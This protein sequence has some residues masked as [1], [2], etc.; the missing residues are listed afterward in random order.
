MKIVEV[1]PIVV[2]VPLREPVKDVHGV[3][4]VQRSVLVRVRTDVG[5]EGWGNVDPHAGLLAGLGA[6]HPR[7]RGTPAL[8]TAV[9]AF[10]T[11]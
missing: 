8:V 4:S 1:E 6:R 11:T 10:R 5:A 2:D 7:H 3:T 9:N